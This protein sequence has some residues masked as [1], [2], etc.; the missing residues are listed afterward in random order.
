MIVGRSPWS[1]EVNSEVVTNA[2]LCVG[3][4]VQKALAHWEV[5]CFYELE[6]VLSGHSSVFSHARVSVGF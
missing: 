6:Q 3:V 4:S 5:V 1:Y 2:L